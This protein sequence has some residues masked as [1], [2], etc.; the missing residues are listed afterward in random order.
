MFREVFLFEL[1]Y[2]QKRA[3]TYVYF[4]LIFFVSFM[5]AASPKRE[6][7]QLMANS[8]YLI[9]NITALMSLVFTVITS[10]IMAVSIIRDFEH[11]TET[12]LFT[13]PLKKIDYLM[14]R[15]AGSFFVLILINS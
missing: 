1:R 14:G 11:S 13:T 4:G 5:T 12:M 2:R 15:F 3:V 6:T 8:P 7:G 9:A 10:A